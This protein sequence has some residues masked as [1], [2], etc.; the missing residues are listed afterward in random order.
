MSNDILST[1]NSNLLGNQSDLSD[2]DL[3]QLDDLLRAEEAD[4]G[5]QDLYYFDK[6][7]LGYADM[8]PKTHKP[9]CQFIQDAKRVGGSHQIKKHL[10]LPRGT[11]K[12]SVVTIG[13]T[14]HSVAQNPNIRVLL[15]NE[16]YGNSKAFLREIKAHMD[17]PEVLE[18]Y[19][20]LAPNKQI[21]DGWTESTVIVKDRTKV[22][23]EPTISCAGLDQI[24][25]GM[26]YDLIIMDDLVSYRNVTSREQIDKVIDHYKLALSL[27]EPTGTII[28]LGTRYNYSDLYGYLLKNEAET[29]DHLIIPA[30]IKADKAQE[31]NEKFPDVANEYGL[32]TAGSLFFPERHNDSFLKSQRKS[33]GTYIFNCQYMLDPVDS[34]TAD[35]RREWFRY[36][37]NHLETDP[38][39]GKAVLVVDWNGDCEKHQLIEFNY[40]LR[41]PVTKLIT[42]DPNNKKKKS[43][44]YTAGIVVAVTESNDWYILDMERNILNTGEIVDRIFKMQETYEPDQL[45][46]EE[47]GKEAIQ[48]MLKEKMRNLNRFFKIT[49]LKTKGVAKEDRIK[50]LVPRFEFGTIYLPVSLVKVDSYKNTVD[51]VEAIEDELMY[52]PVGEHDDLIDALAYMEDL[53][54]LVKRKQR[55]HERKQGHAQ[56]VF[57]RSHLPRNNRPV[58]TDENVF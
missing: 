18:V 32:Y 44:D 34:D 11:F 29:F 49:E 6:Y 22:L 56:V 27:L 14:L 19:P 47:V 7:I 37:R 10:E 57:P 45:G 33:Q 55:G 42:V 38:D 23:K 8:E 50:R 35:F 9:I 1:I 13:N 26:H 51:L 2:A 24:K 30:R 4:R 21:N 40:P 41:L 17:K 3:D 12:T 16:V 20:Q 15:D 58:S 39:T 36:S 48:Y 5:L 25:V 52:F 54:D 31:L 28:V 53:V 46:L 43:S